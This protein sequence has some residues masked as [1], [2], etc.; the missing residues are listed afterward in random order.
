MRSVKCFPNNEALAKYSGIV[1]K[2]NQSGKFKAEDTPMSKAGNCYL[3]YYLI[4]AAGN[5][6][7]HIPEYQRF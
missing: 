1:W 3:W 2:E 5:V 7:M 6:T 4:E